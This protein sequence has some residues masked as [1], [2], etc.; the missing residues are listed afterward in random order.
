M[1]R[2]FVWLAMLC[3]LLFAGL[4]GRAAQ[5]ADSG[6]RYLAI[7]L[8]GVYFSQLERKLELGNELTDFLA[9]KLGESYRLTPRVYASLD[10]VVDER[11][12][13]VPARLLFGRAARPGRARRKAQH[14]AR[15][16]HQVR[17]SAL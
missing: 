14:D 2:L 1:K 10:Q 15:D 7:Y 5:A 11:R 4:D 13:L 9:E 6:N 3:A 8:P 17:N 12:V 16:S